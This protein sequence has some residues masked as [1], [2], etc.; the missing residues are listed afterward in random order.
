MLKTKQFT[1]QHLAHVLNQKNLAQHYFCPTNSQSS[2]KTNV[3]KTI[4]TCNLSIYMQ[5]L[6]I[7]N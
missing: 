3:D 1:Y 7:T 5:G 2:G 6:L 4:I